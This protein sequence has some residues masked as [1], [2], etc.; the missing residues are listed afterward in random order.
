MWAI[1]R[2]VVIAG[3]YGCRLEQ[4]AEA[5]P[6]RAVVDRAPNLQQ[7]VGALSRPSHLLRLVHPSIDQEV[8][9]VL[10]H[11]CPNPRA[12]PVSF[13]T[14]DEPLALAAEISVDLP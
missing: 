6:E 12:R 7:Q 8:G 1:K 3:L 9:C 11:R 14:I 4:S 2:R 10:G 13:A 5:M